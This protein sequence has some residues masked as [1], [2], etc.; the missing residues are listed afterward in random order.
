MVPSLLRCIDE[1][2]VR[3][4]TS[5]WGV[6]VGLLLEGGRAAETGWSL[7]VPATWSRKE[8]VLEAPPVR[9]LALAAA[10][11]LEACGDSGAAA[12]PSLIL[13]IDGVVE[14][15]CCAWF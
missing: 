11:Y 13:P 6:N 9:G 14:V 3:S 15:L 5:S 2:A 10:M 4:F 1:V 12:T 7:T 8:V